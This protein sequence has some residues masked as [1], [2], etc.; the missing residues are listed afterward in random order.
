MKMTGNWKSYSTHGA[1]NR[2]IIKAGLGAVPYHTERPRDGR[3]MKVW[4]P[5]FVPDLE[6]DREYI[7]SKGFR[8]EKPR[9]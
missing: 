9:S 7:R 6:E 4:Q 1:M 3:Q 2:A 8:A 5:V